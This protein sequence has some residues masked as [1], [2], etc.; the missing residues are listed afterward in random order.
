M[1]S[2]FTIEEAGDIGKKFRARC[3]S[4]YSYEGQLTI[5]KEYEIEITTR[6]MPMSPL[7]SFLNDRGRRSEAH[8]ERFEKVGEL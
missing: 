1:F 3:K 7:C 8:L 2:N 4:S 5:D 6:I